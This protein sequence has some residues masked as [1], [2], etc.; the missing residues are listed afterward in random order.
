[1]RAFEQGEKFGFVVSN[2][3]YQ[4]DVQKP[5]SSRRVTTEIFPRFQEVGSAVGETTSMVYPASW[6]KSLSAG[7][8]EFLLNNGVRQVDNFFGEEVFPAIDKRFPLAVV[9]TER[10]C[11]EEIYANGVT[12]SRDT[13]VWLDSAKKR[14]FFEHTRCAEK[15]FA[16]ADYSTLFRNVETSVTAGV[17][18]KEEKSADFPVSV[19][20]K[21]APGMQA[22]AKELYISTD[23]ALK[24]MRNPED[25]HLGKYTCSIRSRVIGRSTIFLSEMDKGNSLF[26]RVFPPDHIHSNTYAA[27]ASFDNREEAENCAKYIN[28]DFFI[29]LASLDYSRIGFARFAPFLDFT[30]NNPVFTPDQELGEGHEFYGLGLERRL[31]KFFNIPD[32]I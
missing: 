13:P 10:E 12:L 24:N 7:L 11:R 18:F 2:P 14:V 28:T 17:V 9:T 27:L 19:Y 5:G 21:R 3:P 15:F 32:G 16:G 1:M 20:I 23:D 22:D 26:A 25:N 4:L 31:R 30:N 6:Q 8:G 29:T